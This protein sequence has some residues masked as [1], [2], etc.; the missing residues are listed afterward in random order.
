MAQLVCI[1]VIVVKSTYIL[2]PQNSKY[3]HAKF[4]EVQR[5]SLEN[6]TNRLIYFLIYNISIDRSL[7]IGLAE[8][9]ILLVISY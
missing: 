1:S 8:I 3:L 2:L 6:V 7:Y 4:Q 9:D 5:F